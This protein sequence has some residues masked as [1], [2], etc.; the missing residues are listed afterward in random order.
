[1]TPERLQLLE[2]LYQAARERQP[3]EREAFLTAACA[4]E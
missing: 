3:D 1:M 2:E 4:D